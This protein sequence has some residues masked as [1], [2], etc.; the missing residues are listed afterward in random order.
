MFDRMGATRRI[1]QRGVGRALGWVC[2]A[3]L[4]VSLAGC[5]GS[6]AAPGP[7]QLPG[8]ARAVVEVTITPTVIQATKLPEPNPTGIWGVSF[9]LTCRETAGLDV[10][11][12]N[13]HYSIPDRATGANVCL[14]P[15]PRGA[16]PLSIRGWDYFEFPW[17]STF[18]LTYRPTTEG[19]TATLVA[20]LTLRDAKGNEFTAEA[21]AEIQ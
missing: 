16:V 21:S 6:P 14:L 3:S 8:P 5:G 18:P 17:P 4:A 15:D 2:A 10:T 7:I 11:V 13:M 12:T 19:H 1:G 9:I 20:T